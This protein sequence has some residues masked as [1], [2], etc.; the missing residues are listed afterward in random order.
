MKGDRSRPA[1][2]RGPKWLRK[3]KKIDTGEVAAKAADLTIDTISVSVSAVFKVFGTILL[4]LAISGLIFGCIFAYY[5]KSCLS[6]TLDISLEDYQLSESS[7]I[8]YADADGGWKEL[9]T[10]TGTQKRVW[11]DYD[12]IPWYMEK[13]LVAIED[14]RFYDHKGVDWYRTAGA[15]VEMFTHSGDTMGGSTITQQLI[16]NLTGK[17]EV[18]VQRKLAEIFSALELEKKYD[19]REIIEWYLNA[20]YFGEGCWGVQTAAQTYFGKNVSDLSLAE[21][22]AIVGI[23]NKPTQY[24]PF[25]DLHANKRRQETI[26]HEMYEQNYISYAEYKAAVDE[27]LNFV[28][29]EN[30]T[31][32]Q[33]IYSYYEEVV[34]ADVIEDLMTQK[35]ISKEAARHLVYNGGYQIFCCIDP[36]I[37]AYIDEIYCNIDNIPRTYGTDKQLQSA[38]VIMDPYTGEI[39]GLSG[40]VGEKT[41]NFPLNRATGSQRPPGSSIK[42][43][44]V[45]GPA[46][47]LLGLTP[48]TLVNDSPDMYL[49]GTSWYPHNDSWENYGIITIFEA[50]QYSLNTVSAQIVDKLGPETCYNFLRER[51]G[52]TSLVPDDASYAPMALGQLTNGI[53]VREMAQ[54]YSAFVN[55]GVFTYSRTYTRITDSNGNIVIDNTP[56]TI[57]AFRPNSA[58][59]MTYMMQNA[60][61]SGTGSGAYLGIMPVAGKTGTSGENKDRWFVGCTPYYVAAV[62]TGYDIPE[63]I[64]VWGNPAASIWRS[65]MYRIHTGLEYRTFNWPYIGG[66]TFLFGDLR[67]ELEEQ[68]RAEEEARRAEEEAEQGEEEAEQGEEENVE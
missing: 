8:W 33:E 30:T 24:D 14:K 67:E 13:A 31:Y 47:E 10:L 34:I 1:A 68:E 65:V 5:V 9:T 44:A 26:L 23:T 40:G 41:Q 62:W 22:A 11:V 28:Y 57:V 3:L 61:E 54:A 43:I 51:L 49:S 59:V 64:N 50:L 16:K 32:T 37:Q 56:K 17:N 7:T 52:V 53:T 58:Y 38:I 2:R 15:F 46:V 29:R 18:T 63:T 48:N 36:Q 42:P 6:S 12:K 27:P 19:K 35:G 60:V 55:D 20:V 25:Y 66:D 4:V 21:C 39:K 45:Y